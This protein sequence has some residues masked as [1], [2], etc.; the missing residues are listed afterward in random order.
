M[1]DVFL[2][3]H[4][5]ANLYCA[6]CNRIKHY[7]EINYGVFCKEEKSVK[8][9]ITETFAVLGSLKTPPNIPVLKPNCSLGLVDPLT[10]EKCSSRSRPRGCHYLNVNYPMCQAYYGKIGNNS[11]F[12]CRLC[13]SQGTP[14]AKTLFHECSNLGSE[15]LGDENECKSEKSGSTTKPTWSFL[16]SFTGSSEARTGKEERCKNNEIFDVKTFRCQSF[17]CPIGYKAEN[18]KCLRS[19]NEWNLSSKDKLHIF[20]EMNNEEYDKEFKFD[21]K[22]LFSDSFIFKNL[23]RLSLSFVL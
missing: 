15:C 18:L 13:Q 12:H 17:T 4:E 3:C 2:I 5:N 19:A 21:L 23:R 6:R 1:C 14:L 8:I 10:D 9:N 20:L 11:N 7:F 16:L 22:S